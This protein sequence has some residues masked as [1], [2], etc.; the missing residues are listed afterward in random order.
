MIGGGNSF[1]ISGVVGLFFILLC[2]T[3]FGI[4]KI[5]ECLIWLFKHIHIVV[6]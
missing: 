1:G 4:W 2:I 5:I 6:Q 3:P